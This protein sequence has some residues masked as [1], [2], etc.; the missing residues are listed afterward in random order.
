MSAAPQPFSWRPWLRPERDRLLGAIA[1]S[2]TAAFLELAPHL[3]VYAAALD[4]LGDAPR[5]DRLPWLAGA[6]FLA[7]LLRYFAMGGSLVLSHLASFRLTRRLRV[8]ITE[9]LGRVPM[10]FFS[11]RAPGDLKKTI[12]SD[13]AAIGGMIEHSLPDLASAVFVPLLSF[14]VLLWVDWRMALASVALLPL[15][16][17]IQSIVM[18]GV[19][20]TFVAWQDTERKASEAVLEF[21]RGIVLLK[22][23]DRDASSLGRLSTAV[24]GIRDMA[25]QMTRRTNLGYQAFM[26]LFSSNLVVLLPIG[27]WLHTH[28]GLALPELV[29]FVALGTGLTAPLLKLMFLFG[30]TH[31]NQVRIARVREV[32]SAAELPAPPASS[33]LRV[34]EAA[35][36]SIEGLSFAYD[37][38]RGP[39]LQDIHLSVPAGSLT[40]LVGPS[41]A[42]KTTLARMLAGGWSPTA[43]RITVGGLELARLRYAQQARLVTLVT[44]ETFLIHGSVADN[45]RLACADA[46]DAQLRAALAGANALS[47]VESLPQGLETPLGDRGARLSGGQ[48]QR[49]AIARAL[50]RDAPV[51]ILDEVT[52]H[53]DPTSERA[54]QRGLEQLLVGRT[55]VVVAHRLRTI[56]AAHQIVVMDGGRIVSVGRHA[57]LLSRC[58]VYRRLWSAQQAA[59]GWTLRRPSPSPAE[60]NA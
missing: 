60:K 46:S 27:V 51:V 57:E 56:T 55:V 53:L 47:F 5:T 41:G 29:L 31:M 38:A 35:D 15:G 48:R 28:R 37:A 16:V 19:G 45:L 50:L 23:F 39:T 10:S 13:T 14:V 30:T 1:L 33:A 6:A 20:E 52:A 9:K 42:G 34:P 44:Q 49:L 32:L 54:V 58:A 22:S 21:L 59:E 43:G 8:A 4:A 17:L 24:W 11:R 26:V 18:S 3:V 36:I 40:A 25:V 7:I 12:I 2:I